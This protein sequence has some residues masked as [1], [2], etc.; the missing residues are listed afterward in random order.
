[1][2]VLNFDL[3]VLWHLPQ[4]ICGW[5]FKIN[6]L[7]ITTITFCFAQCLECSFKRLIVLFYSQL[8]LQLIMFFDS[9]TLWLFRP[10][11]YLIHCFNFN[12]LVHQYIWELLG[13][14]L[15]AFDPFQFGLVQLL[16]FPLHDVNFF[17]QAAQ[18]WMGFKFQSFQVEFKRFCEHR[19]VISLMPVLKCAQKF[20]HVRQ[21]PWS[22]N[23]F[24][25]DFVS[26]FFKLLNQD[27]L[28][29]IRTFVLFSDWFNHHLVEF[30]WY[31]WVSLDHL[32]INN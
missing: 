7:T 30:T 9:F 20:F 2:Q 6:L 25:L 26:E 24:G 22:N 32:F 1:M 3:H 28:I 16:H 4:I 12:W 21:L 13:A 10:A 23:N 15:H 29:F 14:F 8:K 31:L 19:L 5:P 27:R 11:H 18:D 17:F